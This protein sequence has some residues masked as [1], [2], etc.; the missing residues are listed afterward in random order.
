MADAA[1]KSGN[2]VALGE[3]VPVGMGKAAHILETE[4]VADLY[5]RQ[6]GALALGLNHA[7]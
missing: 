2:A 5:E 4:A 7:S 3:E 6:R 1:Q